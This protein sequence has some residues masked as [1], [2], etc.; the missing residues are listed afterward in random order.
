MF[1]I[2]I[3]KVTLLI[4]VKTILY[5]F[6]KIQKPIAKVLKA[7]IYIILIIQLLI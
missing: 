1:L 6:K 5:C 2:F 7:K 3:L 4:L